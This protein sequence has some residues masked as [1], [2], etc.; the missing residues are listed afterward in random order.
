VLTGSALAPHK[1]SQLRFLQA[2]SRPELALDE[3]ERIISQDLS[4]SVRLLRFLNSAALGL[5]AK[6]TSIRH[7]IVLLGERALRQWAYVSGISVLGADKCP[8][9]VAT[10]LVRARLCELVA[11]SC[12]LR[13]R[14]SDLFLVGLLYAIDALLERPRDAALAELALSDEIR[15]T[16]LG[17]PSALGRVLSLVLAY[18]RAA[19]EEVQ[20]LA[21]ELRLDPATLPE[22]FAQ[23]VAWARLA[24]STTAP[25]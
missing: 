23:A 1:L 3:V 6:V 2:I 17:A 16:I 7:A 19:W 20:A 13:A 24:A 4:L 11:G 14:A 22:H 15:D 10:C 9:L 5:R 21:A 25:S 12:G 18:E 8:E